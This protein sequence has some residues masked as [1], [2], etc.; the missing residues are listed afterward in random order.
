MATITT[1]DE[2]RE[3]RKKKHSY[4]RVR[5]VEPF[6]KTCVRIRLDVDGAYEIK[7]QLSKQ[8]ALD[9]VRALHKAVFEREPSEII[10]RYS[11]KRRA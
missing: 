7:W 3:R 5:V 2:G 11:R 1:I 9:L 10:Q 8:D 4:E 6:K